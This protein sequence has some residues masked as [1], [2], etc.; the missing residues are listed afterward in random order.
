M[1]E[2]TRQT[3]T[4]YRGEQVTIPFAFNPVENITGQTLKFTVAK[5]SNSTV[6]MIGPIAIT[7]GNPL[8]GTFSV[9][10]T[11]ELTNLTPATYEFDVWRTDEGFEELKAA[12][13][14]IIVGNARVPPLE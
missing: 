13:D 12:G 4:I 8:V 10:L 1:A 14:F 6:K 7:A 5:A 2:I 3:I 11:E 9:V